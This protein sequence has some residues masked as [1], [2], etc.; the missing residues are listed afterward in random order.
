MKLF[1]KRLGRANGR[2]CP[3]GAAAASAREYLLI[4]S[5]LV[6]GSEE[7]SDIVVRDISVS[8]H[9]AMLSYRLGRHTVTDLG[10]TNGTF[11]NNRRVTGA[12]TVGPGDELRLGTVSFILANP[13]TATAPRGFSPSRVVAVTATVLAF[14]AGFALSRALDRLGAPGRA[15]SQAPGSTQSVPSASTPQVAANNPPAPAPLSAA[16][17]AQASPEP[18]SAANNSKSPLSGLEGLVGDKLGAIAGLASLVPGSGKMAG[19][20]APAFTLTQLSGGTTSLA[21]LQGKTV[22]LNLWS[23]QCADCRK[24]MP[25]LE[26][27]SQLVRTHPDF[28]I[29]AVDEKDS[30]AAVANFVKQQGYDFPVAL[31][32]QGQ[33]SASYGNGAALPSTLIISPKGVIWW[34]FQGALDWSNP[35]MQMALKRFL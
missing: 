22:L 9:H 29:L 30:P 31:D 21:A 33:L 13:P 18:S 32:P 1:G 25:T 27:L 16:T 17:S 6:M 7:G 15:I 5:R 23:I 20:Q 3:V 8:R 11:V 28:Q 34:D 2:L 4:K 14:A 35:L 10:S 19:H 12:T 26:K 24:E